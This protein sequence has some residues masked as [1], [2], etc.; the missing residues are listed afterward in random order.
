MLQNKRKVPE[1]SLMH[2]ELH[3][4]QT[5]FSSVKETSFFQLSRW[6]FFC[7]REKCQTLSSQSADRPLSQKSLSLFWLGV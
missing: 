2:P 6:A 5:V 1:L 3:L 4:F 7:C